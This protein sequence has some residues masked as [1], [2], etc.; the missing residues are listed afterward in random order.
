[1]RSAF[2]TKC[3][4]ADV[5]TVVLQSQ[6]VVAKLLLLAVVLQSQLAVAKHLL[7]AVVL[8]LL[9][10][11]AKHLADATADAACLSLAC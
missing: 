4:T 3:V 2:L 10:A 11:V 7:L 1:M 8:L 9:L 5:T 6:L